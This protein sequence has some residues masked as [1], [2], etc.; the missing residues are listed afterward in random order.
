MTIESSTSRSWS[1]RGRKLEWVSKCPCGRGC[2]MSKISSTAK[3]PGRKFW[4]CFNWNVSMVNPCASIF[5]FFFFTQ[6]VLKEF[7]MF[8]GWKRLW[9][10]SVE[11]WSQHGRNVGSKFR[12]DHGRVTEEVQDLAT[13]VEKKLK[14][15][16]RNM[17]ALDQKME[18]IQKK[19]EVDDDFPH[20]IISWRFRS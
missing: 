15:V 4:K 14:V 8:I 16:V 13:R 6:K 1:S 20:K 5:F 12:K 19:F 18:A 3:N 17:E 9:V 11:W 10:A 7:Y 2:M